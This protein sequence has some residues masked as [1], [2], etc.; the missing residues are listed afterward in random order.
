MKINRI[1]LF[2]RRIVPVACAVLAGCASD[3]PAPERIVLVPAP[4]LAGSVLPND[5][6]QPC[7]VILPPGYESSALDYPVVYY[8]PGFTT[9]VT[10]YV[11]G[12]FF[13][14][15]LDRAL[16][17]AMT[18]GA[19]P[20]LLVV[21]NGRNDLG[22]SFYVNS[23]VTGNWEDFVVDDAVSVVESS[24]R[25]RRDRRFR[26][27]AGESMGGFGALH[28]AMHH[29]GLF[30]AAFA[31][32]PGLFDENGLD[33]Y[34]FLTPPY[35][36]AWRLEAAKMRAWPPNEAADRLVALVGELYVADGRFNFRRG[37]VYAYGAAFSPDPREAPFVAYPYP[38]AGAPPDS[39]ALARF[40]NGFGGLE[41]KVRAHGEALRSLDALQI[42]VGRNDTLDW[43]PRGA[44][45]FA[46]L[47]EEAGIPC[48]LTEHEG[49]HIDRFGER[50]T[51]EMIPF[52][53]RVFGGAERGGEG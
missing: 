37:S 40:R 18:E 39:A 43:I 11:D 49:G 24:Y 10:E 36:E 33:D 44:R 32:S 19:E 30:G 31:M 52:F 53:S 51:E 45:R 46:A 47:L 7:L 26:G 8:L 12:T 5:P 15:H 25:V 3:A 9:S 13:G 28:V 22:G 23:P 34:G 42:D 50:V 48:V 4:S 6:E 16:H 1:P 29:D 27:I 35:A 41:E 14:F 17:A 21:V 20:F 2:G 38:A